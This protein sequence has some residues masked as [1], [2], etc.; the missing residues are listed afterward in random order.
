[1]AKVGRSTDTLD[2]I[3]DMALE[4]EEELG[5]RRRERRSAE[6]DNGEVIDYCYLANER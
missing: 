3:R 2:K 5:D 4:E 6:R 1:M